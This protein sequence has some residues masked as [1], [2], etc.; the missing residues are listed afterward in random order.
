MGKLYI[1]HLLDTGEMVVVDEDQQ[2]WPAP[3]II[4]G[5]LPGGYW[6][7]ASEEERPLI[8]GGNPK[9]IA[10]YNWQTI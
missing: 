8:P 2:P 6:V 9:R 1:I 3:G 7:K 5:Q 4:K 10:S